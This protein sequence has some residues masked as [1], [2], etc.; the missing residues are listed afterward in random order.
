MLLYFP[1]FWK[2]IPKLWSKYFSNQPSLPSTI[3]SQY[4]RFNTFIKFDNKVVLYWKYLEKTN[5]I[6]NLI[7]EIGKFKS[8]E[9]MNRQFKIDKNNSLN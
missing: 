4:L 5:F 8:W 1:S 7:I 2:D 3:T 9:Q 6:N